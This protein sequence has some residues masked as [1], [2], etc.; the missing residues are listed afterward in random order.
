MYLC[1]T[2]TLIWFLNNPLLLSERARQEIEQSPH[3]YVS[4]ASLWEIAIKQTLGKLTIDATPQGVA[5]LCRDNTIDILPVTIAHLERL[6]SLPYVHR[7][8]FDRLIIA[9]AQ[10]ENLTIISKDARMAGYNVPV[11]W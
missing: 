8:P 1:D 4:I 5:Q 3:I 6:H 7:D 10:E 11:L 2:H 9:Q